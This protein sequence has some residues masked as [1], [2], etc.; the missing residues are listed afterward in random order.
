MCKITAIFCQIKCFV[1]LAQYKGTL[2]EHSDRH[3]TENYLCLTDTIFLR[4][5]VAQWV[6]SA[7]LVVLSSVPGD[8][9]LFSRKQD[10]IAHSLLL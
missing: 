1:G 6:K 8:R 4:A 2:T 5:P 3:S 10:S 7:D 9:N